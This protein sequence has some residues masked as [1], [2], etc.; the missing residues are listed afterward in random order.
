MLSRVQVVEAQLRIAK[1]EK[2]SARFTERE[3]CYSLSTVLL[4]LWRPTLIPEWPCAPRPR[5][6][7]SGSSSEEVRTAVC[8]AGSLAVRSASEG[9]AA[10]VALGHRH[11]SIIAS[12]AAQSAL[13]R[14]SVECLTSS[15]YK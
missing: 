4:S 6:R 3:I 2:E 10:S 5:L 8:A 9:T 13:M 1:L 7:E 14:V 15:S 11:T 12:A